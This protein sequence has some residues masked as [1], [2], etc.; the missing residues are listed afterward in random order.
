MANSEKTSDIDENSSFRGQYIESSKII[1]QQTSLSASPRPS[2][3][4][5]AVIS[6]L[7]GEVGLSQPK[8]TLESTNTMYSM[9]T[10]SPPVPTP[11]GDG[12]M[13]GGLST[14]QSTSIAENHQKSTTMPPP[15]VV[16]DA[17]DT[18]DASI[19]FV[20][21]TSTKKAPRSGVLPR[22]FARSNVRKPD[23]KN[24]SRDFVETSTSFVEG[25]NP[26]ALLK[27]GRSQLK[28]ALKSSKPLAQIDEDL[29]TG[30]RLQSE[31]P[32]EYGMASSGGI[33][34]SSQITS[35]ARPFPNRMCEMLIA[36]DS[37]RN[38]RI[39]SQILQL[40]GYVCD[41]AYD[42]QMAVDK[43]GSTTST[44]NLSTITFF[45]TFF[46]CSSWSL[47]STSC[48]LYHFDMTLVHPSSTTLSIH[49]TATI[50]RY[51]NYCFYF[52]VDTTATILSFTY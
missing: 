6:A 26:I 24:R 22:R 10:P 41:T 52:T 50:L 44:R 47:T 3:P 4:S 51:K 19:P 11:S 25:K 30:I 7:E 2:V 27:E 45:L 32:G 15:A 20:L 35:F 16:D 17:E 38:R 36:D 49:N 29:E 43:V 21:P 34:T 28:S 31:S 40:A 13:I 42:G 8:A 12:T 33:S 48:L 46:D 5:R 37:H 14:T 39:M 1:L 18:F 9:S 23:K